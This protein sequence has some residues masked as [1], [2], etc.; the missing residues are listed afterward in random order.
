MYYTVSGFTFA[1]K[2][3]PFLSLVF[4]LGLIAL[5]LGCKRKQP[6]P[7]VFF[8]MITIQMLAARLGWPWYVPRQDEIGFEL[9]S[10]ESQQPYCVNFAFVR[11]LTNL[12]E[13]I[14]PY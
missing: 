4:F 6:V 1:G 7:S 5:P 9:F 14:F 10:N 12:N 8:M 11:N 3:V 2:R 13:L